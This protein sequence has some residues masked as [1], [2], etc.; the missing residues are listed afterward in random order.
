MHAQPAA[1]AGASVTVRNSSGAAKMTGATNSAFRLLAMGSASALVLVGNEV[2]ENDAT[3]SY[4]VSTGPRRGGGAVI[5]A[6][7]PGSSLIRGNQFF[8]NRWDQILVAASGPDALNLSGNADCIGGSNTF[9]CYD[10][11]NMGV[12]LFSN[13]A[14]I[15]ASWNHWTRQPGVFSIDVGGAGVTGFDTQA[16]AASILVCP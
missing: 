5:T 4:N 8:G 2:T 9:G 11:G 6:P 10:A 12:G 7:F 15:D 16:C 13:G 1:G 3:Q 14:L